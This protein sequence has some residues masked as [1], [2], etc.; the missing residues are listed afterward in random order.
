VFP[1]L[2]KERLG[3][4]EV[5]DRDDQSVVTVIELLSPANK[6]PG[7]D[8]EAYINKRQLLLAT[9][10][11]FVELDLLRGGPRLPLDQLPECDY[12]AL[13]SRPAQ[14][15][16]TDVWPVRLRDPL[17]SVPIPLRPGDPEPLLDLQAALH[18]A[19]DRAGYVFSNLYRRPLVPPLSAAD[20][21]W[22]VALVPA[23]A[24][25]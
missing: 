16:A 4:L 23:T 2:L 17:P 1:K 21:A 13:V 14:R 22:A 15:P 19:H 8:R 10:V 5:C 12:Y 6:R 3:Y 9:D 18:T 24:R 11:N 7:G 20:A 25:G